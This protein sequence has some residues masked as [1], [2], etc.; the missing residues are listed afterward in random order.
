M[1]KNK[2]F[3]IGFFSAFIPF[4]NAIS[5]FSIFK[6]INFSETPIFYISCLYFLSVFI[7]GFLFFDPF[8][9][10][11]AL[12]FYFGFIVFYIV[13]KYSDFRF[14]D[15]HFLFV[16]VL[17]LFEAVLINTIIAPQMMPNFPDESMYSHFN[18]G[19]YQRPYSFSG[20]ASVTSVLMVVLFSLLRFKLLNFLLLFVCIVLL[21]SGVGVLSFLALFLRIL[22]SKK[23]YF[24]FFSFVFLFFL[25]GLLFLTKQNFP[26]DFGFFSSKVS[27]GYF[28][29]L[30]DFK[31]DQLKNIFSSF[32]FLD[33]LIGDINN[34]KNVGM[35]GDFGWAY[36]YSGFGL[37]G[38]G[39]VMTFLLSKVS[40]S[41][42]FPIFLM[43]F[44]SLHYPAMFFLPGQVVLG[45]V[46]NYKHT[47]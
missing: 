35:G 34:Y 11:S 3:F 42:L 2:L 4:V 26:I 31:L 14:N 17:I 45:Y 21:A 47:N 29:F 20:N 8:L 24:S 27:N 25:S 1:I 36:F 16:C 12:R 5:Y 19:G 10:V 6:K 41:N 44:F 33:F 30:V 46:L 18:V 9:T 22:V 38:F 7:Y 23:P 15:T 13:F 28:F 32:S 43:V 39:I 40:K 37:F